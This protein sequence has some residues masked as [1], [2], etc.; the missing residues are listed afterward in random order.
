VSPKKK[1]VQRVTRTISTY[2][3]PGEV[4]CSLSPRCTHFASYVARIEYDRWL[5]AQA[6]RLNQQTMRKPACE[7][8]ARKFAA[9]FGLKIW[10]DVA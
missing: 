4:R 2:T 5:N 8:H 10:E 9:K 3:F 6:K 1:A 7:E